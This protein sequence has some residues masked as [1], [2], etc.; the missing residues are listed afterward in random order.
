MISQVFWPS[1]CYK[2]WEGTRSFVSG[3]YQIYH[4]SLVLWRL[5]VPVTCFLSSATPVSPEVPVTLHSPQIAV[6]AY[7]HFYTLCPEFEETL[8][9]LSPDS[10]PNAEL[11]HLH[12]SLPLPPC[13]PALASLTHGPWWVYLGWS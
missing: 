9:L 3:V 12:H 4:R 5:E 2:S 10:Y 6:G 8:V 7:G 11:L 1:E 13:F